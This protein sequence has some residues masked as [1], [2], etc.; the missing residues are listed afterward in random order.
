MNNH[1][2]IGDLETIKII[3]AKLTNEEY[4]GFCK[5]NAIKYI[6]R[7]GFKHGEP[8]VKDLEKAK[9]YLEMLIHNKLYF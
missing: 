3:K 7:A 1:Y 9:D 8:E 4:N 6:T 2:D 5:G